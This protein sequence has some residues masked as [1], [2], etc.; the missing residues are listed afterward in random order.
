MNELICEDE[1]LDT[2]GST[3]EQ[4]KK[5]NSTEKKIF[6]SSNFFQYG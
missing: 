1:R 4:K 5:K 3:V 2:E 6:F